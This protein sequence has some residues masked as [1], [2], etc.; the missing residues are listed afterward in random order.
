MLSLWSTTTFAQSVLNFTGR[1]GGAA[2]ITNPSPYAA[3]VKFTLYNTDGS[4]AAGI[5]NPISQ[6]IPGKGQIVDYYQR[7]FGA[8]PN[9]WVQV[10]SPVSGLQGFYFTGD[11][12]NTFDTEATTP[13]QVQIISFGSTLG[14]TF[15]IVTNPSTQSTTVTV[16]FYD[17]D[18]NVL[19]SPPPFPLASHA[20]MLLTGAGTSAMVSANVGVLA[21]AVQETNGLQVLINGQGER[22][23]AQR[24]VAPFFDNEAGVASSLVLTNPSAQEAR[25]RVSVFTNADNKHDLPEFA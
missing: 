20:Q 1:G 10:T 15:V 8:A 16:V 18:G 9:G 4:L 7:L 17:R 25:I 21:S 11:T 14:R 6:R 5:L 12:A 19:E 2:G 3:D 24:L 13:Q 23:R 22:S